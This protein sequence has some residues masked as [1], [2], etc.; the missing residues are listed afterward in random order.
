M[1]VDKNIYNVSVAMGIED[2]KIIDDEVGNTNRSDNKHFVNSHE[3]IIYYGVPG[4]GKSFFVDKKIHEIYKKKEEYDSHV[5]RV[6]LHP[7]YTNSDFLGQIMPYVEDGIDYRFKAGPFTRILK[8]AYQHH[9]EKFFFVIEEIN[10][11]NAAAIFGE[12]FQLLDREKD[13]F[14]KYEINN[15][16]IASFIMS[17]DD[18]YNDKTV[19]DA[20]EV[21]GDKWILDRPIRLPPNLSILATMNI[22]DQNVFTLD[23]A[24]QRRWQ[25]EYIPNKVDTTDTTTFKGAIK[26]QYESKIGTTGVKWGVFREIV[27]DIIAD[28]E[29]SFSNAEDKQLGLFFVQVEGD[30]EKNSGTISEDD[31]SNKVLKYLWNDI[32]KRDKSPLFKENL[33][34]FGA[35]L[36]SFKGDKAFENCF[37]DE[38]VAKF[39]TE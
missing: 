4:S 11:G 1:S 29:N 25:M 31:F 15:P 36:T 23:N 16:D 24:F 14:S 22:S 12:L 2:G 10:R 20:V 8:H 7:D 18:Y 33:G 5:I 39:K 17:K 30:I 35:L 37:K 34:T 13:G 9:D 28:P 38:L 26:N 6:V 3:Q 21:G 32:F 19:P 27:N